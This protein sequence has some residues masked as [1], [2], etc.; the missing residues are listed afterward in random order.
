MTP[1]S[2]DA[3]RK[4]RELLYGHA[5][6]ERDSLRARGLH[7]I[8]DRVVLADLQ[9]LYALA[10]EMERHGFTETAEMVRSVVADSRQGRISGL[11][12]AIG[13]A[14]QNIENRQTEIARITGDLERHITFIEA[15][16]A[17]ARDLEVQL[18]EDQRRARM[19]AIS[20]EQVA[21]AVGARLGHRLTNIRL[22][23]ATGT[24]LTILVMTG[25]V[26]PSPAVNAGPYKGHVV[27]LDVP[28][29]E[30]SDADQAAMF[31]YRDAHVGPHEPYQLF[32]LQDADGLISLLSGG[33]S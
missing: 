32:H 12:E 31:A 2:L 33:W 4:L 19:S 3:R 5:R 22:E 29:R 27:C 28:S 17:R 30:M 7:Q 25:D 11:R 16:V 1:A 26:L 18:L 9:E 15:E 13:K 20:L 24:P 6:L 21:Q 8:A 10:A 14:R 23:W